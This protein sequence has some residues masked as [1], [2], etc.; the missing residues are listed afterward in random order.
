MSTESK[1]TTLRRGLSLLG[2]SLLMLSVLGVAK[3]NAQTAPTAQPFEPAFSNS[4][5]LAQTTDTLPPLR[6]RLIS[7]GSIAPVRG[8]VTI[9]LRNMGPSEITYE[10]IAATDPRTLAS[11]EEAVLSGLSAPTTISFYEKDGGLTQATVSDVSSRDDAFTVEFT[12]AP[13]LDED[14]NSMVLLETG[15]IFVF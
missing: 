11:G 1:P 6:T 3:V 5:L 13:S 10:A 12:Q 7:R 14:S 4:D 15:N 8:E 2:N 9:T